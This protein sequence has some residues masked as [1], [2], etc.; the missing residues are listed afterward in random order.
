M[1]P[2]SDICQSCASVEKKTAER[3]TL[4]K[5]R[6]ENCCGNNARLFESAKRFDWAED[7][8]SL[9]CGTSMEYGGRYPTKS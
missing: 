5:I 9:K 3:R 7:G 6:Q 1:W 8:G 4:R 2:G